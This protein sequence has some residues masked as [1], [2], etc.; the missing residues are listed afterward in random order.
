MTTANN[1]DDSN[2]STDTACGSRK[3]L[4]AIS[5]VSVGFSAIALGVIIGRQLRQNYKFRR[6][7]PYDFYAHA[8][9]EMPD[10][11]YGVGV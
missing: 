6:R 10:I 4:R 11:D 9:D 3:V 7:T 1:I 5:W 8:G 2:I